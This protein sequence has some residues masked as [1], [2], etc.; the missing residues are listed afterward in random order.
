M[1]IQNK[2]QQRQPLRLYDDSDDF[3]ETYGATVVNMKTYFI[4]ISFIQYASNLHK[5]INK[6]V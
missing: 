2:P 3:D 1:Y 4:C 6:C 5:S